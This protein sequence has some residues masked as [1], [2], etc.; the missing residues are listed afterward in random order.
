MIHYLRFA[1]KSARVLGLDTFSAISFIYMMQRC[2]IILK[3]YTIFCFYSNFYMNTLNKCVYA[4]VYV[5]IL[6]HGK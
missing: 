4:S 5:N 6:E 1:Y 3:I 2:V